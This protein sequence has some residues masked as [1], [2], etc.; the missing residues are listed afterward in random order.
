MNTGIFQK[1]EMSIS[2]LL[3]EDAL[4]RAEQAIVSRDNLSLN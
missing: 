3:I 4:I 1:N 2:K